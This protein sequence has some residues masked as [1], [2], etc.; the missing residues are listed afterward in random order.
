[1]RV[2][3]LSWEYPPVT[4]GGLARHVCGLSEALVAQGAEVHVLSRGPTSGVTHH[5]GVC[6]HRVAQPPFPRDVDA[7]LVW[8]TEMNRALGAVAPELLAR[9]RFDVVHSHDWLVADVARTV[10]ADAGL[11]WL[12]TVHA[13][14]HGRHGGFVARPPQSTIHA[15]ERTMARDADHLITCSQWMRD[16]VSAVF[17]VAR[18]TITT[19]PNGI[20]LD[21]LTAERQTGDLDALTTE[22]GQADADA[23]LRARLAPGGE[24]LVLLAGRLVHEKGFDLAL[25][26][27]ASVLCEPSGD[28]D[29]PSVRFVVAGAGPAEDDLHAQSRRL[30]LHV[31]GRFLGWVDDETLHA[32]YRVC[33]ICLIPSRY[34]PFGIVALEAMA[35]GCA[36][37]VADTGGLRE[38]VPGDETVGVRVPREDRPALT[39]AVTRLLIDDAL[40]D[41]ITAQARRHV[42]RYGWTHVAAATA[43]LLGA[44]GQSAV[45]TSPARHPSVRG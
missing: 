26:A 4:E 12:V 22:R 20:D 27:L 30:G 6:V 7:F 24:R 14:E 23:A 11:P 8:V 36:C 38:I 18:D 33:D 39:A 35:L 15:H 9:E 32:L 28:E 25:D 5:R 13:T 45:T 31:Y 2:L 44:L 29:H 34:E 40:R 43:E 17:G 21:A 37:V 1:M 10:A 3:E 19:L 41:R 16:H 42:R